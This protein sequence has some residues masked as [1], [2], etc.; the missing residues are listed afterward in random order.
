MKKIFATYYN[1]FTD[2]FPIAESLLGRASLLDELD[3][4]FDNRILMVISTTR[5]FFGC[6]CHQNIN[7]CSKLTMYLIR[8]H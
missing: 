5:A 4:T 2:A 6:Q 1:T 3:A 7:Y 8:I